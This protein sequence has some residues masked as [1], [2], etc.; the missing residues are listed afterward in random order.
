MLSIEQVYKNMAAVHGQD[1]KPEKIVRKERVT[2]S[3]YAR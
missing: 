2:Q 3:L 1:T